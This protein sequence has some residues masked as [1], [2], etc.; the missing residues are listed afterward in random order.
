MK[1]KDL[2]RLSMQ[3]FWKHAW[4]Y[5]ALTLSTIILTPLTTLAHQFLPPLIIATIIERLSSGDFTKGDVWGSFGPEIIAYAA[6]TILGTVIAWRVVVILIW[7]L[8]A[9]VQRDI[10]QRV[11]SHLLQQ[12]ADF[13]ANHFGGSL[14]S[15]TN[16]L[17]GA[18]IRFADTTI[19]QV[20]PFVCSLIFT[21]IILAH[22]AP[23]FVILLLVLAFVYMVVAVFVTR[24]VRRLNAEE[25]SLESKQ[26][27]ILADSVTNVMAIKS[28]SGTSSERQHFSDATE[29][30][31]RKV[32]EI[33]KA[34]TRQ[35]LLFSTV[36][37]SVGVLAVVM[38]TVGVVSHGA[39]IATTFLI[40]TYTANVARGL[41]D[42]SG[43][44]LRSYNRALGDARDMTE[45]LQIEPE[46]K[47]PQEPQ[48]PAIHTGEITFSNV[49][50]THSGSE[51]PL[52]DNLSIRI[53]PGEKVGL[54]GHSGSG[55]T[56]LTRI[57]LRFSDIQAGAITID[58]QNIADITQDDLRRFIAYVPQEPL[59]FHRSI[60]ENIAYGQPSATAQDVREAA[61]KAN[62]SEFIDTLPH[63]YETMVGE[64][65]VK[66]SGGQRQRI[67]IAR[68]I[69]KDA[70]ILVLDEATSALDSES[71]V[72]IQ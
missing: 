22:R 16:K 46:V 59:L 12:S 28:F 56:T 9:N 15:Q 3:L 23:V 42:F 66:L 69:L 63:G 30:T 4:H 2:S 25:A 34:V 21:A 19:F 11:Y 50:F 62:A 60:E 44:V 49:Q 47:D 52:F 27:G 37:S 26:T 13:H 55:K 71:E 17:V 20:M 33:I 7:R 31:R 45:I 29:V 43:S 48:K 24:R 70:P 51:E 57:L 36:T 5:R 41:W 54:V 32:H 40:V 18:Y 53:K 64:R 8:E 67:A 38:A 65:G 61:R 39:D 6:L 14:V 10:L 72:L 58:G 1:S 35:D 68:A